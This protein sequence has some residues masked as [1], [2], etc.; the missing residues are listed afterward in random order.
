MPPNAETIEALV[1]AWNRRD[2]EAIL[3][4]AD[5]DFEYVNAPDAVE[6]GTQHGREGLG[7]VLRKQ[8]EG[9][10]PDAEQQVDQ[11]HPRGRDEVITAGRVTRS[12][13]G[14]SS[15]L[16]NPIAIR[17]TFRKGRVLRLEILGAGS[18]FK[19]ALEAAGL[20]E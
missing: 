1:A 12:M 7:V 3:C 18:E 15:R 5:P 6:A 11:I 9:L 13:P 2:E 8:W 16:D 19:N 14:S 4:L 10:G 17:W 20:V